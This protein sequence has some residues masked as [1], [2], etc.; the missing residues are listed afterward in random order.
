M[1]K[2]CTRA[3]IKTRFLLGFNAT[4]I[5]QELHAV[6][7]EGSPSYRTVAHWIHRFSTG[8]DSLEDDP[9]N[10]RPIT[11]IIEQNIASVKDLVKIDPHISYRNHY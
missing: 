11:V 5:H 4:Q 10:G 7:D 2:Q 3:Y 9:R 1:D 6:Y 8:Q